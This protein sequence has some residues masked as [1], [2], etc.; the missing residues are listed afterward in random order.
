[1]FGSIGFDAVR[2]G[3]TA[4]EKLADLV[5]GFGATPIQD[6]IRVGAN[7]ARGATQGAAVGQ[8]AARERAR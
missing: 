5:E 6:V 8:G 4:A 3:I 1:M 2:I 7:N